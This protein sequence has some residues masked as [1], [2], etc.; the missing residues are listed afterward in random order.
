MRTEIEGIGREVLAQ[1]YR[2]FSTEPI[3]MS[4][5]DTARKYPRDFQI[6][7]KE[8]NDGLTILSRL[9]TYPWMDQADFKNT[10]ELGELVG[11]YPTD[12]VYDAALWP[13]HRYMVGETFKDVA[14]K[15]KSNEW[16]F[17]RQ[18]TNPWQLISGLLIEGYGLYTG[19]MTGKP[20]S[21][22]S[23]VLAYEEVLWK[24]QPNSRILSD[25]LPWMIEESGDFAPNIS[26]ALATRKIAS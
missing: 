16:Q 5:I 9:M 24:S 13:M 21:T 22:R 7:F 4:A 14:S 15:I 23:F 19:K 17:P 3:V 10:I 20:E 1:A 11:W 2:T 18:T 12:N 26:R 6:R 8:F 25:V